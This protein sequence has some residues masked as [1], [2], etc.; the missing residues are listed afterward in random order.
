[1]RDK[2]RGDL[3]RQGKERGN[4][5][6]QSRT[7]S[8]V[9]ERFFSLMPQ[10]TWCK[11]KI[12]MENKIIEKMALSVMISFFFFFSAA[13]VAVVVLA[14]VFALVLFSLPAEAKAV[15]LSAASE[16]GCRCQYV[17]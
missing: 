7:Y 6:R 1:M 12:T 2:N 8:R 4:D 16:A 9:S 14:A 10:P 13:A 3:K 15:E 5:K 17:C 11:Q